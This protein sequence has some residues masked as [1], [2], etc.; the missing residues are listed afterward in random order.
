MVQLAAETP[1]ATVITSDRLEM[2]SGKNENS[3][4][5]YGNVAVKGNNLDASCDE[6]EVISARAGT[7]TEGTIGE[8]GAI[9]MIILKKNVVIEQAGRVARAGHAEIYPDQGK[10]ILTD[11]PVVTDSEGV[12]S[13]FRMELVQGERVARVYGK[14]DGSERA[15]V[16]LPTMPDLGYE[17][18]RN[19]SGGGRQPR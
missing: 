16:T 12:V 8:I 5:F 4:F 1:A 9:S 18:D 17:Q 2:I 15:R 6:M 7:D 13:G 3:F 19:S 11:N 10:V 14:P